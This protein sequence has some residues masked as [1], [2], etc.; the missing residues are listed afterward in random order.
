[1]K[2]AKILAATLVLT[3]SSFAFAGKVVVF[4]A[5]TAILQT[6]KAK[7]RMESLQKEADYASLVAQAEG[8]K[9]ELET[10]SKT[11]ESKGLTWSQEQLAEHRKNVQSVQEDFQF[12]VQ[13]IQKENDDLV[14]GLLAEGQQDIPAVLEQLV[15]AEDIEIILRKEATY[16]ALPAA[17]ITAKVI[18]EL[19]KADL[20]K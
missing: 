17:D 15:K 3:T 5:Q 10:L 12:V 8:L 9:S 16:V 4:D 2:I 20:S 19:N 6:N 18:A 14:K 1:M 11:A 13:K 7:A